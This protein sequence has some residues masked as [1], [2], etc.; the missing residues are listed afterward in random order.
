MDELSHRGR[1]KFSVARFLV[2]LIL[3]YITRP[4]LEETYYGDMIDVVLMSIVMLAAVLAVGGRR[5]TLA[6]ATLLVIPVLLG[7]WWNHVHPHSMPRTFPEGITIVFVGFIVVNLFKFIIQ[8]PQV[9]SEVLSA[10]IANYLML[11][12]FWSLADQLLARL[13]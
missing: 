1:G 13:I 7:T 6:I 8:A 9:T 3:L 4:F 5:R 11:G 12:L 2:A 10:G